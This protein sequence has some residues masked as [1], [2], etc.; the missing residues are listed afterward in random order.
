VILKCFFCNLVF[1]S[2]RSDVCMYVGAVVLSSDT[3]SI[4][5]PVKP[6]SA[7]CHRL[8]TVQ[9]LQQQHSGMKYGGSLTYFHLLLMCG[10]RLHS[11]CLLQMFY[12]SDQWVTEISWLLALCQFYF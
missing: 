9:I 4:G 1:K 6:L 5:V 10:R 12:D 8:P 2:Y 7:G 3:C 11:L